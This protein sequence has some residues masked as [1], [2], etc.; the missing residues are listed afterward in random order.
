M[1][2]DG[3]TWKSVAKNLDIELAVREAMFEEIDRRMVASLDGDSMVVRYKVI[4]RGYVTDQT[5]GTTIP[6]VARLSKG[7]L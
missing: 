5:A 6:L 7:R 4:E 3:F 1:G 2:L